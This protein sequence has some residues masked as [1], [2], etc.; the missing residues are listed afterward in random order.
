MPVHCT[1]G[2]SP[3]EPAASFPRSSS[4]RGRRNRLKASATSAA[5]AASTQVR[6]GSSSANDSIEMWTIFRVEISG[7]RPTPLQTEASPNACLQGFLNS[8]LERNHAIVKL[9]D[10]L[11][12]RIDPVMLEDFHH[13]RRQL[14]RMIKK[15]RPRDFQRPKGFPDCE[16]QVAH[17]TVNAAQLPD[18]SEKIVQASI[19]AGKEIFFSRPALFERLEMRLHNLSNVGEAPALL[20]RTE[21][22]GKFSAQILAHHAAHQVAI[23]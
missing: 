13:A 17:R 5:P 4:S 10:G 1:G 7:R 11:V 9:A 16:W 6:K 15:L 2:A 8:L 14:R 18:Y 20:A 12:A 22:P 23:G 19:V 21:Q 3:V